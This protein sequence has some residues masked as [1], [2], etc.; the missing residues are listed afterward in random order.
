MM[1][2]I[3]DMAARLTPLGRLAAIMAAADLLAFATLKWIE[4]LVGTTMLIAMLVVALMMTMG[5]T[6]YE[7]SIVPGS[8]RMTV[9]ERTGIEIRLR[10]PGAGP[11]GGAV[12]LLSVSEGGT[13]SSRRCQLP[14]LGAGR[15][16]MVRVPFDATARAQ[17]GI[18]PLTIRR[19]DPFGLARHDHRL[20]GASVLFVHPAVVPLPGGPH[21]GT[22]DDEGEPDGHTA[23][24]SPDFQGLRAY[25]DGDDIRRVHWS[26]SAKAGTLMVRQ[27]AAAQRDG[28]DLA[29]DTR[30]GSYADPEEFELAVTVFASIG[31]QYLRWGQD[32]TVH[33]DPLHQRPSSA[34]A[35]LDMCSGIPPL[36][37]TQAADIPTGSTAGESAQL[38][39]ARRLWGVR[40]T[41]SSATLR[42]LV[43]GS[44]AALPDAIRM[45]ASE[46]SVRSRLLVRI[47]A[48]A[49]RTVVRRQ[50]CSVATIGDPRDLTDMWATWTEDRS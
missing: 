16:A 8:T 34:T 31:A 35:L 13:T 38:R 45:M 43:T 49:A 20:A 2:G 40:R 48:G 17:V 46:P 29:L 25:A 39:D 27:Y 36:A 28:L 44:R 33:A 50:S 42:C 11:I 1:R 3:M 4:A 30:P 19:G 21:A 12:G 23:T 47:H 37:G 14:S 15:N 5:G 32:V 9:G 6:G 41:N 18:G 22:A 24:D 26:A 7:A 10:N